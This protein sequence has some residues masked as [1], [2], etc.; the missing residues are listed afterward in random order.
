MTL[1]V[2]HILK[3]FTE[4]FS[5]SNITFISVSVHHG[6]VHSILPCF[7]VSPQSSMPPEPVGQNHLSATEKG[8]WDMLQPLEQWISTVPCLKTKTSFVHLFIACPAH[9][10][11]IAVPK[12]D[13]SFHSQVAAH[14]IPKAP[15][16]VTLPKFL[17]VPKMFFVFPPCIC[18]ASFSLC[19]S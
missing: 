3:N 5:V 11:L 14:S 10:H 8:H 16:T 18:F 17:S 7:S 2:K 9:F 19:Q 15:H 13:M 12:R 1:Y 4:P 6:L